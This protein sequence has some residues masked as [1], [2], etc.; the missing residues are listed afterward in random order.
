MSS[1]RSRRRFNFR[2]TP[3]GLTIFKFH[4]KRFM[5]IPRGSEVTTLRPRSFTQE[6]ATVA[7]KEVFIACNYSFASVKTIL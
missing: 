1:Q 2:Q 5:V 7:D 4:V 6:P 3:R